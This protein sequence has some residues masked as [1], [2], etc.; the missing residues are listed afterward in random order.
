MNEEQLA[1]LSSLKAVNEFL[2][3]N[4]ENINHVIKQNLA[5]GDIYKRENLQ[6][7][8]VFLCLFFHDNQTSN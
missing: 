4:K 8:F 3:N 2:E 5:V 1:Y 7:H 6:V